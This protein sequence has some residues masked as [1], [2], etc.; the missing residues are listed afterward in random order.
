[1]LYTFSY[2]VTSRRGGK[3][4]PMARTGYPDGTWTRTIEANLP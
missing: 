4:Y 2:D 3:I 1:M